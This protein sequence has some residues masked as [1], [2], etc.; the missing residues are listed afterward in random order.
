MHKTFTG[1]IPHA[2]LFKVI[3]IKTLVLLLLILCWEAR[4]DVHAQHLTLSHRHTG[5]GDVLQDVREQSGY[6]VFYDANYLKMARPVTV[7]LADATLEQSLAAIFAD[8][9][10][11]YSI[12]NR[13][14]VITPKPA[15]RPGDGSGQIG[16]VNEEANL[17]LAYPTVT[18]RVTDSLGRPLAGASVRVLNAEGKRTM[19]QT[20]TDH[21]G[22]FE[23]KHV[24]DDAQLEITYIGYVSQIVGV[25][26]HQGTIILAI[27]SS[28]ILEVE[29]NAGYYTVKDRLRTGN[30]GSISSKDIER[31][32]VTNPLATL[33]GRV[34]GL[35][36]TQSSGVPG[37]SFR[38]ELRGRTAI[39]REITDDQ[40]LFVIDGVPA[41]Q[42]NGY[43]N[44]YT[45]ALGYPTNSTTATIPGG[46]SP[47]NSLNPQDI[48][49]IEVLKDADATA[50]YGSRGANG[51]IL[52][53]TKKGSGGR[54][55]VFVNMSTGWS[56]AS[57][58]VDMMNTQQYL[59]MRREAFANDNVTMTPDNSFDLLVWDTTRYTDFKKLLIGGTAH[60]SSIQAGISGG[61][62]L[63]QF[64]VSGAYQGETTVFPG[65]WVAKRL[66][67]DANIQ[68]RSIDE[69][70]HMALAVNYGSSNS[71]LPT[72]DYASAINI[73]PNMQLWNEDG[74]L[75]WE[76]GGYSYYSNPLAGLKNVYT[77]GTDN[78]NANLQLR[79]RVFPGVDLRSSFGYNTIRTDEH[80]TYAIGSQNPA[81]EREGSAYFA[82]NR[83]NS[84][85]W[86]PQADYR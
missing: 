12:E 79:Y 40:P 58:T 74:E 1:A 80:K 35:V 63:T 26:P 24:P 13:V 69:R 59:A 73:T 3:M 64:R 29:V 56:R 15:K 57:R 34:P 42:N 20:K 22:Y 10:F 39:D 51:V 31:Q 11:T 48:E 65:D 66:T 61:N 82:S 30:I 67:T 45:S 9:P 36:I 75:S 7:E 54:T 71:D 5:L 46:L 27:S 47:L 50:I 6:S 32:P 19:L 44:Q 77:V 41:A 14:I 72:D 37:S 81:Y 78:L 28:S 84:W 85:I 23:L 70:L 43:L 86:E 25:R 38:V 49:R 4:A 18:G 2:L 53:T 21:D 8:Q 62:S 76:E 83:F 55:D 60:T 52:I 16:H 68:H 33:H 17:V